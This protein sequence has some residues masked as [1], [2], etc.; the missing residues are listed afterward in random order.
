MSTSTKE[1][2]RKIMNELMGARYVEGKDKKRNEFNS[3][4][5]DYS[6]EVCFGRTWARPGIDRKLRSILNIA[7]LTALNRPTQLAYHVD[8]AITNGCTYRS[9]RRHTYRLTECETRQL[10]ASRSPPPA[11]GCASRR[12]ERQ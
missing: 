1:T 4:L 9:S 8:G 6:E 12:R 2:G 10:T 11:L 5:F 3:V 7:I